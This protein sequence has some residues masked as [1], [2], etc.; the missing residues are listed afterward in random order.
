MSYTEDFLTIVSE[1]DWLMQWFL[2]SKKD[3]GYGYRRT[4]TNGQR[5]DLID[6]KKQGTTI[7]RVGRGAWLV[8]KHPIL[9]SLFDEVMKVLAKV[10][11]PTTQTLHEKHIVWV[12]ELLDQAPEWIGAFD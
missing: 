1:F 8:R 3:I 2:H 12:L 4:F 6:Y 7:L 10:R 5:I 11:I 9:Y